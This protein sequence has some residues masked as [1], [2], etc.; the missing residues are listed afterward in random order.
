MPK[1]SVIVPVG[2]STHV[3]DQIRYLIFS[4]SP[5]LYKRLLQ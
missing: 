5:Q 1:V 2:I 3:K 4:I